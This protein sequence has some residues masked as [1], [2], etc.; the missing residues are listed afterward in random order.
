MKVILLPGNM[1]GN[2]TALKGPRLFSIVEYCT[3]AQGDMQGEATHSFR[4][5]KYCTGA[6]GNMQGEATH[7]YTTHFCSKGL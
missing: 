1:V 3:G 5:M 4:I 7:R 6:E 2:V